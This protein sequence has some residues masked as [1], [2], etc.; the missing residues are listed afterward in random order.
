MYT[1]YS[2]QEEGT[3]HTGIKKNV[4]NIQESR[5]MC[6]TQRS[7]EGDVCRERKLN[8]CTEEINQILYRDIM[9]NQTVIINNYIEKESSVHR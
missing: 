1:T 2:N 9:S 5:R 4:H 7:Q 6:I 3:Q 8:L